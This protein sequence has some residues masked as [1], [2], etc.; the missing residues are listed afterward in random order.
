[1]FT[2]YDDTIE[3]NTRV[4]PVYLEEFV[5]GNVSA[6]R[7]V[8][9]INLLEDGRY[10]ILPEEGIGPDAVLIPHVDLVEVPLGETMLV[11]VRE[12]EREIEK[13]LQSAERV[14]SVAKADAFSL[15]Q[16]DGKCDFRFFGWSKKEELGY[17]TIMPRLFKI[18]R[19]KADNSPREQTA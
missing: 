19:G 2:R 4:A 1:M 18:R 9:G 10:G 8:H 14:A 16:Y 15:F 7:V 6:F 13:I 12:S 3:F 11:G 5:H 17:Y